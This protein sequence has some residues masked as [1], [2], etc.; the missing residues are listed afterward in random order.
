MSCSVTLPFFSLL[1]LLEKWKY[2]CHLHRLLF[3]I[4][5]SVKFNL[6]YL[7]LWLTAR[8]FISLCFE[9][10]NSESNSFKF[11]CKN[12]KHLLTFGCGRG[13]RGK[14][15]KDNLPAYISKQAYFILIC[16]E[17][18][19]DA[20]AASSNQRRWMKTKENFYKS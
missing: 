12:V 18:H 15:R 13:G 2:I 10:V 8:R 4:S 11:K 16:T 17:A 6:Q 14:K 9:E 7:N 20:Y 5:L 3:L 19:T 1:Y